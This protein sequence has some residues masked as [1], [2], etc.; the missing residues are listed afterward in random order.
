[1]HDQDFLIM[2][3]KNSSQEQ[4]GL[5]QYMQSQEMLIL[6]AMGRGYRDGIKKIAGGH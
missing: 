4:I 3:S 2:K 5:V 6:K 1:M